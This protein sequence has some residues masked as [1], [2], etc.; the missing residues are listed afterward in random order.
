[1]AERTKMILGALFITLLASSV[2]YVAFDNQVRLRVDEDQTTFYVKNENNRWVV[3]GR[4]RVQLFDGSSLIYRD[5][6][7]IEVRNYRVEEQGLFVAERITPYQRGPIVKETYVFMEDTQDVTQF[8][9]SHTI[10]VINGSGYIVQYEARDLVYDGPSYSGVSSPQEFGRNMKLEWN[11][12]N[13]WSRVYKSGILKIRW[14]PESAEERY[15]VRLFDPP[16]SKDST[17]EY[18]LPKVADGEEIQLKDYKISNVGDIYSRVEEQATCELKPDNQDD[19]Y[20]SCYSEFEIYDTNKVAQWVGNI[21]L[22]TDFISD[23][24]FELDYQFSNEFVV[25]NK[26]I[27]ND[28]NPNKTS[29]D[30]YEVNQ[31]VNYSDVPKFIDTS[32]P[33]SIK[34]SYETSKWASNQFNFSLGSN[35]ILLNKIDPTQSACGT[36]STPGTY[37][38]NQSITSTGDCLNIDTNDTTIDCNGFTI[39][40]G[41]DTSGAYSGIDIDSTAGNEF[42]NGTIKNCHI[43]QGSNDTTGEGVLA[44]YADNWTYYNNTDI[45]EGVTSMAIDASNTDFWNISNNVFMPRNESIRAVDFLTANDGYFGYN[46][47]TTQ[48]VNPSF[49]FGINNNFNKRWL[50][51][52]NDFDLGSLAFGANCFIII[53]SQNIV[54]ENNNCSLSSSGGAYLEINGA[55]GPLIPINITV[56]NPVYDDFKLISNDY[57]SNYSVIYQNEWG[58]FNF[59]DSS[60]NEADFELNPSDTWG[61]QEV[62]NISQHLVAINGSKFVKNWNNSEIGF[63]NVGYTVVDSIYNNSLYTN[64]ASEVIETGTDCYGV[65]CI[66][67]FNDTV[68]YRF[69]LGELP[70]AGGTLDLISW[71]LNGTSSSSSCVYVSGDWAIDCSENCTVDSNYNLGGNDLSIIGHG[72]IDFVS[73]ITS[74]GDVFTRGN[75]V[76]DQCVVSLKEGAI[77]S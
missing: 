8:P 16:T 12:D 26:S 71:A 74:I 63:Y 41:D 37:T 4:E 24:V 59:T 72:F 33:F 54:Y 7:N 49:F 65:D 61:F 75:S 5:A 25:V 6:K 42:T 55:A 64:N 34:L 13:Y 15:V 51:E 44:D 62:V 43:R 52:Y 67:I 60:H 47:V 30:L 1:M 27:R 46:N 56:I 69:A 21:T 57:P 20:K 45:T 32:N 22:Q 19:G 17:T 29:F 35:D 76:T 36:I 31:F 68:T 28:T 11:E 2:I 48:D 66:E 3:G 23:K 9:I 14:K 10:D 53:R 70:E 40:W 77:W 58:Y 73:N 18:S 38:L 50:L 39:T